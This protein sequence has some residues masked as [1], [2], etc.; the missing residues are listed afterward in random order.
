[1]LPDTAV[2]L[3]HSLRPPA[4]FKAPRTK[5]DRLA[6]NNSATHKALGLLSDK[7][8]PQSR[9]AFVN[10]HRVSYASWERVN[11]AS[12]FSLH[13]FSEA[14]AAHLPFPDG[15]CCRGAVGSR[16][17][18]GGGGAAA[19]QPVSGPLPPLVT[20]QLITAVQSAAGSSVTA[21]ISVGAGHGAPA[22][23]ARPARAAPVA[24][25]SH[26][27]GD[28]MT[29]YTPVGSP[30][31]RRAGRGPVR[32]DHSSIRRGASAGPGYTERVLRSEIPAPGALRARRSRGRTL[33]STAQRLIAPP[34]RR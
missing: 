7:Y 20:V 8:S 24:P 26:Q 31:R 15:I 3:C 25:G 4:E 23:A 1:M 5:C 34:E 27:T 29:P 6:H 30:T 19:G 2:R 16:G 18:G 13:R 17:G 28:L 11:G 10:D 21:D 22:G 9:S 32:R 33:P 12:L 14:A